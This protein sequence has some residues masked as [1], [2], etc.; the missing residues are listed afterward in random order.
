MG[1]FTPEAGTTPESRQ[2]RLG[3]LPNTGFGSF[4]KEVFGRR[5]REQQ[6]LSTG[7]SRSRSSLATSGGSQRP[8]VR[9]RSLAGVQ[10]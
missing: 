1:N 10:R 3:Q 2:A 8:G 7:G 5:N 4:I 9:Q 6:S